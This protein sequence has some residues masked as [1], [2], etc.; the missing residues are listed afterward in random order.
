MMRSTWG[1]RGSNVTER[2]KTVYWINF[3]EDVGDCI[4]IVWSEHAKELLE[5]NFPNLVVTMNSSHAFRNCS[6]RRAAT[7]NDSKRPDVQ[8]KVENSILIFF[9]KKIWMK[10][11]K[12][13]L[14]ILK[15]SENF[16]RSTHSTAHFTILSETTRRTWN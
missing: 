14:K 9:E 12:Y 16:S 10:T 15:H 2:G 13:F 8:K 1:P 5:T 3:M 7:Y 11:M 6:N 4:Q